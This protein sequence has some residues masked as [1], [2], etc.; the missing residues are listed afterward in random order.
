[1]PMTT[2]YP[3][4]IFLWLHRYCGCSISR[5]K[6]GYTFYMLSQSTLHSVQP[7]HVPSLSTFQ[8]L[9]LYIYL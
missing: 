9:Y 3:S 5:I 6:I 1:M 2:A 7:L 8:Y 4:T